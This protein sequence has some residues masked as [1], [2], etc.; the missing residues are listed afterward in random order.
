ML[1]FSRSAFLTCTWSE[2]QAVTL[3]L[4][5]SEWQRERLQPCGTAPGTARPHHLPPLQCLK[6][7]IPIPPSSSST[8]PPGASGTTSAWGHAAL[9]ALSRVYVW[10]PSVPTKQKGLPHYTTEIAPVFGDQHKGWGDRGLPRA[11]QPRGPSPSLAPGQQESV[12]ILLFGR[13]TAIAPRNGCT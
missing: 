3:L 12:S 6:F 9:G 2:I 7:S 13:F 8:A 1:R 11:N 4:R 5:D 10:D